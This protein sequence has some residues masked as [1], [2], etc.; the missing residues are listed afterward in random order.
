MW[1]AGK[2]QLAT[3]VPL[4][5]PKSHYTLQVFF[6]YPLTTLSPLPPNHCLQLG[7]CQSDG[8]TYSPYTLQYDETSGMLLGFVDVQPGDTAQ[9]LVYIDPKSGKLSLSPLL[10]WY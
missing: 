1:I 8:L 2:R 6:S 4:K 3:V 10:Y 9:R 5:D 7:P